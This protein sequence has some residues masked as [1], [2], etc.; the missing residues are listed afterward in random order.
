MSLADKLRGAKVPQPRGPVWTGP[1]DDGPNGGVTFSLLSRFLTCRERFR[2]YAIEGLRPSPQFNH[3]IEYGSMWHICEEEVSRDGATA[4]G[5]P[6]DLWES[7][8]EYT[9]ALCKQYPLQQEQIDHWYN[10]CRVQFPLY[11]N[12]WAKHPDATNR[13]PFYQEKVF[14]LPYHLPSGRVVRLRGKWDGVAL[15]RIGDRSEIVLDEHKTK[16]DIDEPAL[17]RQLTF[18][19]Q[20]MLYM[21][22]L[23]V[24]SHNHPLRDEARKL[25]AGDSVD[26]AAVRYNVVRRPLSGGKGTI[27]RHKPSKSNPAGE[28]KESFY[29]RVAEY[30][31]EEPGHYFM[32]WRVEVSDAD[33]VR[34]RRRCLDP[35]LE[36]LC[37]W[38]DLVAL[39]RNATDVAKDHGG[40]PTPHWQHPFGVRNI[41]DEG[42]HTDLDEYLSTGSTVGLVRTDT[43]FEELK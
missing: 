12:Y 6:C 29:D 43:L 14:D 2:V 15:E 35:L 27:V 26:I 22:A 41:L 17:R 32:R 3:R 34:F 42:G 20:T 30:I 16:G 4:E 8:I 1:T 19:L 36:H 25:G 38:Y 31:R 40:Y 33:V 9:K 37:W 39:G 13:I 5:Y 23:K 21:V 10:V 18:D 24:Y 7:L 11:V 28:S